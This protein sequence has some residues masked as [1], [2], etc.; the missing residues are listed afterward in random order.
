MLGGDGEVY[1]QDE[2]TESYEQKLTQI[3]KSIALG[4]DR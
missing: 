1:Y 4:R 2:T 3:I